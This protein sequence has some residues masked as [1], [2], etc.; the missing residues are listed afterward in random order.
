MKKL[1]SMLVLLLCSLSHAQTNLQQVFE[2]PNRSASSIAQSAQMSL[3]NVERKTV[4]DNI[5][6]FRARTVC[7]IGSGFFAV[8]LPLASDVV[9][10]AR[11][12]RY[13]ITIK[14]A[15]FPEAAMRVT[16]AD[17]APDSNSYTSCITGLN[18]FVA[19]LHSSIIKY[20]DF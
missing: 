10:E 5:L 14:D 18:L 6:T 15:Y 9:L 4:A 19:D 11:E 13:R 20:R 16:L 3:G 2:V 8:K 7:V 1:L 17:H 12:G